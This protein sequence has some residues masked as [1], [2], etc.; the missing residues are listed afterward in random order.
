MK[1]NK[2]TKIVATIG[3]ASDSEEMIEKLIIAG[4]NI[5]R[6]NL[7]HNTIDWHMDRM[8]RVKKIASRLR[9]PIGILFDLQGPAL[10]VNMPASDISFK[11]GEFLA[12]GERVFKTKEKGFSITYPEIIKYISNGQKI[13]ADDGT[14][15]FYLQK[16]GDQ[17]YL[18]PETSGI[19][20][21]QKSINI[22]G[23]QFPLPVLTKRDYE[24]LALA[25][26]EGVD[27]VALSFVRSAK[28][29]EDVRKVLKK[30]QIKA[31]INSKIETRTGI[32][33]IDEI[34]SETD[35][36]MIGRGD[37]GVELPI[38]EVPYQQKKI[39][40]KCLAKGKPVITATQMLQSMITS[41]VP[42]R[43]E[44]SDIA[45]AVYDYT[46]AVMLS[47]E[48]AT[49]SYPLAAVEVMAK[50]AELNE[51]R[52]FKDI[53]RVF[54]FELKDQEE[55]IADAAYGLYTPQLPHISN[56]S[57]FLV[58][59]HSGRTA[60][61]IARYHPKVP[62]FAFVP[63]EQVRGDLTLSFGVYPF[64]RKELTEK[65]EVRKNDILRAVDFLK[66]KKFVRRS[67]KLIVLHGDYWAVKGGTSTIKVITVS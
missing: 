12:F 53:R 1:K 62:I 33:N 61:L 39:I 30:Y 55:M 24:G 66:S 18:K 2:L 56:I 50:T 38:E 17:Y 41:P 10:R 35:S 16:K 14:L 25:A 63:N 27:I 48:S 6:F 21:N 29:I 34:V 40:E 46:D 8:K 64:S 3:P 19:L 49:G 51:K 54:R 37:L 26:K 28:D 9:K 67:E 58:F 4:V 32:D 5:F 15:V 59:T 57:G 47:A 44:V 42:T 22:P 13:L 65:I 11:K 7:K 20:K 43:A 23:A 60:R 45:N 36:I 52:F 31:T